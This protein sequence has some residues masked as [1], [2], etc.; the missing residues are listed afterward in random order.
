MS[1]LMAERWDH[2][3]TP[4]SEQQSISPVCHM[5]LETVGTAMPYCGWIV[6]TVGTA[7]P[8]CCSERDQ[9][10]M[11]QLVEQRH[12]VWSPN[13]AGHHHSSAG[14]LLPASLLPLDVWQSMTISYPHLHLLEVFAFS[15]LLSSLQNSIKPLMF[16][17][18]PQKGFTSA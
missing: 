5:F 14:S 1:L 10:G 8:S 9:R 18:P 11:G 16:P 17:T 13:R 2:S 4:Q 6:T 3:H 12:S 7:I 15:A